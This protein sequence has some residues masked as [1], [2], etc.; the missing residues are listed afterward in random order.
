MDAQRRYRRR[1]RLPVRTIVVLLVVLWLAK[2]NGWIAAPPAAPRDAASS[3]SSQND[4]YAVRRVVDGDTLLLDDG[5]RVRLTGVNTPETV[6]EGTPVQ[7]WGPEASQFTKDFLKQGRVRLEFDAER[8]DQHGRLLAYA[9]VGPRM[10]NEELLRAGL[11]R[12][13][14]HYDYAEEKKRRFRAAQDEARQA[15]RG[16]WSD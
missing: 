4:E 15:R 16:L 9:W 1:P 8:H 10:L 3:G 11:A 2:R 5:Q 6:K 12:Y 14:P 7:P 13:E